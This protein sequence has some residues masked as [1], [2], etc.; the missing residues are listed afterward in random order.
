[1]TRRLLI[2]VAAALMLL[3]C[4]KGATTAGP[5]RLRAADYHALAV[6]NQWTYSGK[7]GGQPQEKTI[8]IVGMRDGFFADDANGLLQVDSQGLRDDKRYLL[9]EPIER[10]KAWSSIV[11]VASTEHYEIVDVGFT[12]SVPAGSFSDCVLVRGTNRIDA[13]KSLRTEWTFAPGVGIVRIAMVAVANGHEIPQGLVE[14]KSFKVA[15]R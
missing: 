8:T 5:A 4:A 7:M 13:D 11:S 12:I 2:P 15:K 10:G 6:G 14:L 9:R 3:G 1:M